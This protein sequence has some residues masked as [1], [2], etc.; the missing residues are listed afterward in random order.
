MRTRNIIPFVI[1]ITMLSSCSVNKAK[2]DNSLKKYFDENNVEGCFTLLNNATGRVTVYNM[3]LDTMRFL[4]AAT[5]EIIHSLVGLQNG[6]IINDTMTIQWDGKHRETESWNKDMGMTDAFKLSNDAYYKEVAN[7]IGK[8]VMQKWLDSL[9]FGNKKIGGNVDTFWLDNSLKISPDE[10]LG[11]VK[12]LYFDQLPFRKSV[13]EMVRNVM[14]Q[15]NNTSYKL[16]Y[17]TGWGIDESKNNIG[18]LIGWVEENNH[19]YFFVT[20]VKAGVGKIDVP[21]IRMNITK[22]ILKQLGFLEGKK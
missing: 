22:S 3:S 21:T 10:Q 4:P 17:K 6:V 2:I 9:S 18:W 19:V 5:F 15:E 7:R 11:L 20:F 12:R 13:H 16:S 14:L 8:N 1:A